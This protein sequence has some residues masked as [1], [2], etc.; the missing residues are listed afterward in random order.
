MALEKPQHKG[1]EL[2]SFDE[3]SLD[4]LEKEYFQKGVVLW[5]KLQDALGK[6]VKV[7]EVNG[8]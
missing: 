8:E 2:V 1:V 6:S 5:K 4:A 7:S 3:L